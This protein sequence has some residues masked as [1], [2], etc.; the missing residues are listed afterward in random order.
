[1]KKTALILLLA[2]LLVGCKQDITHIT[3]TNPSLTERLDEVV[4]IAASDL[5]LTAQNVGHFA[6]YDENNNSIPYEVVYRDSVPSS[7]LFQ[8]S[9]RGGMQ[10]TYTWKEGKPLSP[11]TKVFA[12]FV[13]ERKDDFAF[14]NEYAA[15]RMY[16]PALANEY[17]SNGV[18]LWLKCTDELV[19]DSFYYRELQQGYSYHIDWGKG[20][21]CYKVG[22]TLGCGGI[23]PFYHDSLMVGKHYNTW[24]ILEQG[25]LRT[26]FRL[27]YDNME[28]TITLQAGTPYC[29]SQI[30]FKPFVADMTIIDTFQVAA[31]IYLHDSL[32]NVSYQQQGHWIAYAEN[33]VSDAGVPA[34]RN[35]AGVIMPQAIETRIVDNSLL[36]LAPYVAGDTITYYFAGGWSKWHFPNDADWFTEIA[37]QSDLLNYPLQVTIEQER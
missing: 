13:P 11:K 4:E 7:I 15:Y 36:T 19:V 37:K 16:G 29:Q 25:A 32:D 6:L 34:G 28:Q 22:H 30:V 27:S 10:D 12:R 17:P 1:M 23:A 9:I 2:A 18:D 35:Y 24:E 3:I 26:T 20:L 5:Q 8:V 14:E 31:G 33:A 21:D